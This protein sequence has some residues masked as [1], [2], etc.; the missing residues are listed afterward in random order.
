MVED[1]I[2]RILPEVMNEVLLRTIA[3]AD[4]LQERS[5]RQSV[6]MPEKHRVNRSSVQ[7]V[8]K[9]VQASRRPASLSQ[10]LDPEAGADFYRDPR[11]VVAGDVHEEEA[12]QPLAQ[13]IQSLPPALQSLA[14]GVDLDDDGGEMWEGEIGDSA[15]TVTEMGPPLERA[16]QVVGLDFSRMQRAIQLT[17]KKAA[18]VDQSDARARAQFE[19]QRIKMMRER[20]N[21]GKPLD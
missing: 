3:N 10:L 16:A 7:H 5:R 20:L 12:P 11:M 2:R 13:R 6:P 18:K 19:E 17:E 9:N 1:A 4:V 21:D 14:E 8:V 15:I